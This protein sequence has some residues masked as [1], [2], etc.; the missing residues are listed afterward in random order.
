MIY[1]DELIEIL[2]RAAQNTAE[3]DEKLNRAIESL[4]NNVVLFIWCVDDVMSVRPDLSHDEALEVLTVCH[5]THDANYGMN[6]QFI[7]Y[8]ANDMFP[9]NE[10]A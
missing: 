5:E 2:R 1:Q 6:W 4:D 8:V 7:E 3:P 9:K 10:E